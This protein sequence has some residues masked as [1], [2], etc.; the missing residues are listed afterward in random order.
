MLGVP[1]PVAAPPA[2]EINLPIAFFLSLGSFSKS[3][4]LVIL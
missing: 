2:F 3:S 1:C 4:I